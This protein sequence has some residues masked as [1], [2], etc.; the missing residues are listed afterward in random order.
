MDAVYYLCMGRVIF[1]YKTSISYNTETDFFA[2]EGTFLL[3][4]GVPQQ[5]VAKVKP[6]K[7]K[8]ILLN[9][10][11]HEKLADHVGAFP[12]VI[13]VPDDT[14]LI[15]EGSEERR[16]FM[17][18]TL[19]QSDP[20]YLAALLLYNKIL[21]QRNALLKSSHGQ[22]VPESLLSIYDQQLQVPASFIYERR[23]AFC[24]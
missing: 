24:D 7:L 10:R 14:Q 19:S 2:Y 4:D 3:T 23:R 20:R 13:V 8:E 1:R 6:R 21:K 22:A 11:V 18:N 16:R 15:K 5:V 9:G 17:D 12:V